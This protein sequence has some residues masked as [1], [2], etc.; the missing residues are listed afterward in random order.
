MKRNAFSAVSMLLTLLI[1]A[2]IAVL[3]LKGTDSG[4]LGIHN[5]SINTKEINEHVQK[6]VNE[7]ERMKHEVE[8]YNSES[9]E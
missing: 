4:I 6:Q 2:L 7:I 8:K 1:I 9:F 3:S 5:S